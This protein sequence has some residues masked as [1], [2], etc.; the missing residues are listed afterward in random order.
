[1]SLFKSRS[2]SARGSHAFGVVAIMAFIVVISLLLTFPFRFRDGRDDDFQITATFYPMYVAALN[3]AGD[4]PGVSIGNLTPA[5]TGCLHDVQLSANELI[6][7]QNTDLLVMN[8]AGAEEFLEHAVGQK[9]MPN[10]VDTSV[11]L[12]LISSDDD[13]DNHDHSHD[14]HDEHSTH[15]HDHDH[16]F[17]EHIWMSPTLYAR[18]VENLRDA[19]AEANPENAEYYRTNAAEYLEKIE[20]ISEDFENVLPR[21]CITFHGSLAYFAQE[22]GFNVVYELSIGEESSVSAAELAAAQEASSAIKGYVLL[23][24]D[25]QYPILYQAAGGSRSEAVIINTAVSPLNNVHDHDAWL[26]AMRH[27]LALLKQL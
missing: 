8:G 11:G 24:Y 9:R 18:Q 23:I 5:H 22:L 17:N 3:V 20:K 15:D 2:V 4:V 19:L 14:S 7:L 10:F 16:T 26:E 21:D 1:M 12:P 13:H 6:L 27:N 25:A